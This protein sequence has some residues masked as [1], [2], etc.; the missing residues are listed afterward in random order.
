M[1]ISEKL[2]YYRQLKSLSLQEVAD[3]SGLSKPAI[4]QYENGATNP[5][6]KALQAIARALGVGIW[7]F[8]GAEKRNLELADFRFGDSLVDAEEEKQAVYNEIVSYCRSYI[9]LEDILGERI[10][11]ENPIEDFEIN[12]YE[13]VEIAVKK[14]R[15]K[16]KLAN[17]AVDDVSG[18]LEEKGI[19][20]VTIDRPTQ[21]PGLCG[22]LKDG[23][24]LVPFIIINTNTEHTRELTRKRFTIVHEFCHLA[25]VFG[26][27][28]DKPLEE[29]F[30][31]RF[32]SAFL[33]P[34]DVLSDYL[35]KDRTMISLQEL[36]HVKQDYGISVLGIIYRAKDSSLINKDRCR[37]WK[38]Q[39]NL[40]YSG[41]QDFGTYTK[42]E[43]KPSRFN[44]LM[45]K[46]LVENRIS[47]E[48]A[49][50]LMNIKLDEVDNMF[51]D[52][53]FT[54]H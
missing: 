8:F 47:K 51:D 11:F 43:E 38:A 12:T 26:K 46:A 18:L 25:S 35:G 6:N 13:D 45:A 19:K 39:Y 31:N 42:S 32:A 33:L 28:V 22:Y 41:G 48:K 15:K 23:E 49:A 27:N 30:C 17:N 54:M 29:K 2:K 20:I 16:W 14:V 53:S 1:T 9:E 21:S 10:Y 37:D 52:K 40:W 34:D 5:S 7:S 3:L 4:Q 36:K 50:E 24:H 44:R